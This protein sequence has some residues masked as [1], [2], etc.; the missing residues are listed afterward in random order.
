MTG[1]AAM[2]FVV[3]LLDPL[4]PFEIDQGNLP[5]LLKHG[6]SVGDL[7][8]LWDSCWICFPSPYGDAD[9]IIVGR[10]AGGLHLQAPLAPSSLGR[11]DQCRPVGLYQASR[12][13][14]LE[15]TDLL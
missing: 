5:H 6:F 4:D 8:D 1:Q 10:V 11:F 13:L 12:A 9:W 15:Y 7:W 2:R 3:D 14:T